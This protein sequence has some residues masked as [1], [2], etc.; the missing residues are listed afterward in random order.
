MQIYLEDL[1]SFLKQY[2]NAARGTELPVMYMCLTHHSLPYKPGDNYQ[3]GDKQL[4][5]QSDKPSDN[6]SLDIIGNDEESGLCCVANGL[7]FSHWTFNNDLTGACYI[8][9]HKEA[10]SD[11]PDHF[12]MPTFSDT[13]FVISSRIQSMMADKYSNSNIEDIESVFPNIVN[14]Y[15]SEFVPHDFIET[16]VAPGIDIDA[17]INRQDD[18]VNVGGAL[19]DA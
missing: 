14:G 5:E 7:I 13:L 6:H 2:V 8:W 11:S 15:L 17:L 9:S 1:G 12:M 4:G 18:S 16:I 19:H 3:S 10:E